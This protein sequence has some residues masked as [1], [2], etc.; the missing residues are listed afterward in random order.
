MNLQAKLSERA[1]LTDLQ[2]TVTTP[3]GLV[4]ASHHL[5]D[6][7]VGRARHT[8]TAGIHMGH[9]STRTGQ[10]VQCPPRW[11]AWPK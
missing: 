10:V 8:P 7:T 3:V 2:R 11:P 1:I 9:L 6:S 5:P 4:D